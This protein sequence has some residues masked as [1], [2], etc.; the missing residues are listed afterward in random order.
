M[1]TRWF[2]GRPGRSIATDYVRAAANPTAPAPA[3]YPIQRG[4]TQSMR[5]A[6]IK[7]NDIELIQAWAGQSANMARPDAAGEVVRRLW[8]DAQTLLR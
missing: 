3:P 1:I 5:D 8:D 2:S 7:E 6:A 4:L